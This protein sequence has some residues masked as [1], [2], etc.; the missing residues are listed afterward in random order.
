[1][2][3]QMARKT[4]MT[5][6]FVHFAERIGDKLATFTVV[7]L[8]ANVSHTDYC[9]YSS[10]IYSLLC[11]CVWQ[12]HFQTF[13]LQLRVGTVGKKALTLVNQPVTL[14]QVCE[15]RSNFPLTAVQEQMMGP[16]SPRSLHG[17]QANIA[18]PR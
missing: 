14:L 5:V 16:H 12:W 1:M 18:R 9:N 3:S 2:D 6:W 4:K 7:T 15:S 11:S 10:F 13:C 8:I 17:K